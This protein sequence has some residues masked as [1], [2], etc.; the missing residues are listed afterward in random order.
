M[1]HSQLLPTVGFGRTEQ[2][3][4]T[5]ASW[6]DFSIDSFLVPVYAGRDDFL[7][8]PYLFD[9]D[10]LKISFLFGDP[11]LVS[12]VLLSAFLLPGHPL[13]HVF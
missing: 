6:E 13:A 12:D 8:L 3:A 10:R 4:D 9:F 1:G 5:S 7:H 11:L 2:H